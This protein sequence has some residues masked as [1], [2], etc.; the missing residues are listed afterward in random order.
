MRLLRYLLIL[1]LAIFG[2]SAPATAQGLP[3]T[4]G[5]SPSSFG[6]RQEGL[7]F[8]A[9]VSVDGETVFRIANVTTSPPGV[10]VAVRAQF[11][12]A[13]IA[14][15]LA[16]REQGGGTIFDPRSLEISVKRDGP[17]AYLV[18][19]DREHET[20]VPILTVTAADAQYNR[21]PVA[22]LA[23]QWRD[24]LARV[25]VQALDKRQPA[26]IRRSYNDLLRGAAAIVTLTLLGY[27]IIVALRNAARAQQAKVEERKE[28]VDREQKHGQAP[29]DGGGGEGRRR[30]LARAMR[31]AEPESQLQQTRA[32]VGSIAWFL[33]LLWAVGITWALLLFPNTLPYGQFV[34]HTAAAIAFI[35]IGAALINRLT[36]MIIVRIAHAYS[37]TGIT[38]EDRARHVLRAPTISRALGSFKSFIIVFIAGLATL[39]ALSIPVASV[40]TIGGVA[41]LGISFAAQNLI[42]DFLNGLL[43]LIE[44]Q[45]VVGD[46]VM[47]GDYNGI[48]ENLSLRVVQIRDS[49]GHLITIPHSAAIQVV[50]ASRNWSRIDYRVALDPECDPVA[51]MTVVREVLEALQHDEA[52]E[53]AIIEPVEWIGVELLSK[54][55]I[56]LRASVR[57][58][59]LRQFELRRAM[60]ERVHQALAE[61]GI[62]LGADPL[63]PPSPAPYASPDPA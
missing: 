53:K 18:A 25:L 9:P 44:D 7:F 32:I 26:Q 43:V 23:E 12:D 39:S 63:A 52:F 16:S 21:L 61:A 42:R 30:L 51:A 62:T 28:T 17:E 50:N 33:I 40:I 60:N 46:Y 59:P 13:A 1:A 2:S 48:V 34:M 35:W 36:D 4:P 54:N 45:Y 15:I 49:R 29:A 56:V 22:T 38:S 47:I 19:T 3:L 8:T 14:Q 10:P 31:A 20:P 58:A 5:A 55:A 37:R 27:L 11:I 6:A 24:V 57:T 41:A